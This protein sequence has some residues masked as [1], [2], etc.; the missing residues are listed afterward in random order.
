M[1]AIT[2]DK[3]DPDR[4][5]HLEE[6]PTP[7]RKASE[8]LI[9]VYAAGV[10]RADLS[11]RAGK[12]P[13]PPGA[14]EILGLEVAGTIAVVD[15]ELTDWRVGDRVCALLSG[16]GYAEQAA[17]PAGMLM[18]IPSNLSYEQAAAIPEAFFTAYLNLFIEGGLKQGESVLIHAGAS[19]VGT[20]A[21]QLAAHAGC[22]VFVTVGTNEKA[23]FCRSLGA[24]LAVNY[25]LTEFFDPISAATSG[26]GVDVIL[27]MVGGAYMSRNL[28]LLKSGGRQVVLAFMGGMKAEIDLSVLMKKRLT[29]KGSV[30][31][32]R[33]SAE[34]EI[35]TKKFRDAYWPAFERGELKTIIDSVYPLAEASNAH[36]KLR[37]N[38]NTGK[39]IL[40]VR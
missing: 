16:G 13:P 24:E 26:A 25:R 7:D 20:A 10:N 35:L 38:K 8:V 15:P 22:R 14:S 18:P 9:D 12:Y 36:D 5:L 30:L 32:S 37:E 33:S 21:I 19:G 34:K 2:I 39:V 27:D 23:D 17:V 40:K 3:N 31:R 1:K 28:D 29:L 6:Q 11:Q 4:R